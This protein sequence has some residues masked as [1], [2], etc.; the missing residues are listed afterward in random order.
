MW[1]AA[2]LLAVASCNKSE[3]DTPEPEVSP[4]TVQ[5]TVSNLTPDTKAVKT[6]WE[7]GDLLYVYI[8]RE[9]GASY[10]PDFTLTYDGSTWNSTELSPNIIPILKE[11]GG[12]FH[13]F[14]ED[15][16]FCMEDEGRSK[17]DNFIFHPFQGNDPEGHLVAS[18]S[19]IEYTF[20]DNILKANINSW[21]FSTDLQIVI[22]GLKYEEGR[23]A[24]YSDKVKAMNA[25]DTWDAIWSDGIDQRDGF[26][27]Q[28]IA[29][30]YNEDGVAFIGAI[31]HDHTSAE[32]FEFNLID[33]YT[34]MTCT[35][36]KENLRL[37]SENRTK[38]VAVKIAFSKFYVDL[39]TGVKW[40]A[41]NLGANAPDDPG[42]YYAWGELE[43]YYKE[44]YGDLISYDPQAWK[45]GK[46]N[47]YD[48]SSYKFNPSGDG[49]TFT[50]Y[51]P[52]DSGLFPSDD[53]AT[54]LL[55]VNW[56][57]PSYGRWIALQNNCDFEWVDAVEGGVF[58]GFLII[59]KVQGYEGNKI[60]IP[61]SGYRWGTSLSYRGEQGYCW[62]SYNG[63]LGTG[64]A[65]TYG[66]G[67]EYGRG[68][69]VQARCY[70][71]PIRPVYV[72]VGE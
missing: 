56:N 66:M 12:S 61:A 19:D 39:G 35:F 53:A 18:F 22:S 30:T 42:D 25:I 9:E 47:G 24:L 49:E 68:M 38:L 1:M 27:R 26:P 71:H 11:S 44:G 2:A 45:E 16:N 31:H 14:W 65:Y 21:H 34:G 60:F 20:S 63:V 64:N 36:R 59:S 48:W 70:G 10:Y 13:G 32:E 50:R 46:E 23:Y 57:I 43:P 40:A 69:G 17:Y 4:V 29:G 72:G 6:G 37:N 62:T 8:D 33:W 7:V 55:G 52:D 15:T 54:A 5:I 28:A 41:C 58:H 3:I 51:A 67:I